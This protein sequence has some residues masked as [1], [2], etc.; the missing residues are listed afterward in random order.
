MSLRPIVTA[1][2]LTVL[3][4]WLCMPVARAAQITVTADGRTLLLRGTIQEWD[5]CIAARVLA[6]HP[7][8]RQARIDSPGGNAWAGAFI[9]RLFGWA[10]LEAVVPKGAVAESA[11]GVAV[12][13]APR[14]TIDGQVGLHGPWLSRPDPS[15]LARV[16][17]A[18]TSAEMSSVLE[19]SGMPP[20]RI[21]RAMR[22]GRDRLYRMDGQTVASFRHRGQPDPDMIQRAAATCRAVS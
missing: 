19:L 11:A 2:S 17:L 13:G 18:E 8:I 6:A 9:G 7:K 15:A 10:G 16:I 12:L 4:G 3:A 20:D 5:H 14:R 22:T 1:L 21:D